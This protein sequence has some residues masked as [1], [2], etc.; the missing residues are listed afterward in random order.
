VNY[1]SGETILWICHAKELALLNKTA[2]R[3]RQERAV[4][5][6]AAKGDRQK[7]KKRFASKEEFL[8]AAKGE[9]GCVV[10]FLLSD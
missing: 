7:S 6:K 1:R 3:E 9:T 5:R 10:N 2:A 4:L 8:A